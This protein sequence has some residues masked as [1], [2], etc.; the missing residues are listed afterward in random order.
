[1]SLLRVRISTAEEDDAGFC[2]AVRRSDALAAVP[3]AETTPV[4]RP[5]TMN[6]PDS[7]FGSLSTDEFLSDYWQKKPLLVRQAWPAFESPLSPDAFMKL[8]ERQDAL[9][10]VIEQHG[11]G[12]EWELKDGP[13]LMA[14]FAA[15]SDS[16]WT[17]LIQEVDRLVPQVRDMLAL[18]SFLPKWRLDD[19][20]ISYAANGGGVGAHIDNYDVFLL[21]GYGE[22]RWQIDTT[23]VVD[24]VLVEDIDV[25]VLA[26]FSPD[27]DWVVQPGDLLYLPPRIAHFGVALGPC[28]TYSIGCRA[29]SSLEAISAVLE[30]VLSELDPDERFVDPG[31]S[32][33]SEPGRLGGKSVDWVRS[34]LARVADDEEA[35]TELVG[36]FLSEPRRYID[37]ESLP[38]SS[39][40]E[41]L[42]NG[43]RV[44]PG[45]ASQLLYELQGE[46][47]FLLFVA[48]D[49]VRLDMDHLTSIKL[50]IE[51]QGL[52]S[53]EI[54]TSGEL[55]DFL[56][57]LYAQGVLVVD[58]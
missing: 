49:V 7:F 6:L 22:R 44:R 26:N 30:R 35:L 27:E 39:L 42:A 52:S 23:P 51:G 1:M 55:A 24:E 11:D 5:I 16:K 28:M 54:P 33:T 4:D 34:L 41:T 58:P 50:L 8:S 36:R 17:L 47:E 37:E 20:M 57:D 46:G 10:R 15:M 31:I 56:E 14:D 25:A 12:G 40:K 38:T 32:R 43:S 18:V 21:Q 19:I 53:S 48:G 3:I 45:S 9:S 29:P 13:F 2:L